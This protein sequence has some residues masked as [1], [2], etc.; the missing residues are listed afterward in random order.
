MF[1]LT[2]AEVLIEACHDRIGTPS[3]GR[4]RCVAVLYLA[5]RQDRT[6]LHLEGQDHGRIPAS[7]TSSL[8]QCLH[9][10]ACMVRNLVVGR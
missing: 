3:R 6:S 7:T 2:T 9:W 8:S 4:Q 5:H 10:F 1:A